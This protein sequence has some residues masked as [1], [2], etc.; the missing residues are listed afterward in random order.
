MIK[1]KWFLGGLFG[2]IIL[3]I[4]YSLRTELPFKE[5][6]E[7]DREEYKQSM[8]TMKESPIDI[9]KFEYF[10]YFEPNEDFV[11]D[12]E[13]TENKTNENFPIIMT[14]SSSTEIPLA[15]TIKLKIEGKDFDLKVFDEG[16]TYLLPFNDSTNG[17]DT[18]GGGRYINISKSDAKNGKIK[19]DF[20]NAHN[21]Y[22]AYNF[23]YICPIPPKENAISLPINAGEKTYHTHE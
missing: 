8:L 7:K 11:F 6:T 5:K 21:F 15:G 14:D 10:S 2:L 22:C 4:I 18:Y 3:T 19:L 17:K 16:V 1:N 12:C 13:Y 20:N 23:N 9:D